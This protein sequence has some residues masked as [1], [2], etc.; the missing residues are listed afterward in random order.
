[1]VALGGAHLTNDLSIGLRLTEGQ[2]DKLKLRFGRAL[3]QARDRAE[4]VWLDGNY[5]IGDR[6]FPRHSIEQVTSAR[7]WELM[8]VVRKKAG[9]A[10]SPD[11]CAAGVVL[12]GGTAKLPGAAECAAKVFGVPAHLG[13]APSW[14]AENLRDPGYHTALGLLYYGISSRPEGP[15]A[16]RRR[17]G[18][19][20]GLARLFSTP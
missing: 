16:G 17:R 14:V 18:L 11:T 6:Q 20:D 3:P 1:V 9:S 15:V 10:F 2:A 5:S 4:K 7:F 13:E 8:E 12:T 19:F